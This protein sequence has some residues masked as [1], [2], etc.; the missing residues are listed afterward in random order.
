MSYSFK[1]DIK[2]YAEMIE[3]GLG[4][5]AKLIS[6]IIVVLYTFGVLVIF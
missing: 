2:S 1:Y 5:K 3:F 4:K 6:D